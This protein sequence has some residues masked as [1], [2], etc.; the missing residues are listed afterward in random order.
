MKIKTLFIILA[1]LFQIISVAGIAFSKES[2]LLSGKQIILQTAPVDPRDIFKGDYVKLDYNFSSIPIHKLDEK[3]KQQGVK[4]GQQV[5]LALT[6]DYYGLQQAEK[7]FIKPPQNILYLTGYSTSHWPYKD[8]KYN[9]TDKRNSRK[10]NYP[11]K[12]KFGIEQYFVEQGQGKLLEEIR[13]DRESFQQPMLVKVAVSAKGEAIIHS[14]DWANI[15]MKTEVIR[16]AKRN[17]PDNE[18]NATIRFTLI[19]KGTQAITLS[20]KENNCSFILIPTSSNPQQ[21]L[22]DRERCSDAEAHSKTLQR[23]ETLSIDF[24]LNQPQ[25]VVQ[26]KNKPTVLSRL[27][28]EYR[29]RIAYKGAAIEG[30]NANIVSSAFHGRGNID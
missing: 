2:I 3:I 23:D 24:D 19:N 28:W 1:I 22:F 13:G 18:S 17:A 11:V 7:L 6:T 9:D 10:N 14:F 26:H 12:V 20:L 27:P 30:I 8:Y 21:T 4:K 16:D 5:Y 25:W 15:A 29:Y